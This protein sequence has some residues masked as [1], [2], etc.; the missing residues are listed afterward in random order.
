MNE[1][2]SVTQ[3]FI[4]KMPRIKETLAYPISGNS[5][6]LFLLWLFHWVSATLIVFVLVTSITSGLGITN[7]PFGF[8]WT[9]THVSVGILILLIAIARLLRGFL[10]QPPLRR[11]RMSSRRTI[12]LLLLA[13]SLVL[14]LSGLLIFQ[15]PPLSKPVRLFTILPFFGIFKLEH[16]LH[17]MLIS[18]HKIASYA[19]LF[20]LIIHIGFAIARPNPRANPPLRRMLW[21]WGA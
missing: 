20:I 4:S 18:F 14:P 15:Q 11:T 9:E 2:P 5:L 8:R 6:D 21:P 17:M 7:R 1:R 19:F 16:A 3:Q 10:A 13:L 12:Q